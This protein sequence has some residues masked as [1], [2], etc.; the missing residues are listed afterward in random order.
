[1]LIYRSSDDRRSG[2]CCFD[3]MPGGHRLQVGPVASRGEV[4]RQFQAK[5]SRTLGNSARSDA[6]N[7]LLRETSARH[8]HGSPHTSGAQKRVRKFR[9]VAPNNSTVVYIPIVYWELFFSG[10]DFYSVRICAL[11]LRNLRSFGVCGLPNFHVESTKSYFMFNIKYERGLWRLEICSRW[12][13]RKRGRENDKEGVVL[14]K[15]DLLLRHI[16][17]ASQA[18]VILC[19]STFITIESLCCNTFYRDCNRRV[20]QSPSYVN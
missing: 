17:F 14:T 19:M 15:L 5:I 11:F 3:D 20:A 9:K 4:V 16:T 8:V 10:I 7:Q 18:S 2:A 1:M 6:R 12:P 13:H